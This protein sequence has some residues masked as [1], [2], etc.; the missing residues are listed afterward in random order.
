MG[1]IKAGWLALGVLVT[2]AHAESNED[3]LEA[4]QVSMALGGALKQALVTAMKE[5]GP[6]AAIEVCHVSAMP[7][8]EHISEGTEWNLRRTS[9]KV[10]N[11]RNVPG[12]WERQQLEHFQRQLDNGASPEQLEVLEVVSRDGKS[13]QRYMKAIMVEAPCLACHGSSV[14]EPVSEAL[15]QR[16]PNDQATGYQPGELRGAFSLQRPIP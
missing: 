15:Q 7:I 3:L 6:L 8:T 13:V 12:D 2:T 11:P 10:R 1:R 4:R 5:G 9:E 16:Y 14:S